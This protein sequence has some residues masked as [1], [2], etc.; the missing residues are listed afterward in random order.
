MNGQK[1]K[2]AQSQ[3]DLGIMITSDA[4]IKEHIYSLV[5]K[6][7]KM[8]GFIR[9]TL[10][11]RSDEFIPNFRSLYLAFVR[12]QLEYASEIWSPKSTTLIKLREEG[13]QGRATS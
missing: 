8:L 3:K 9:R 13:I 12:S 11:S 2:R 10:N 1:M 7:S 6:A 4:R 5:S